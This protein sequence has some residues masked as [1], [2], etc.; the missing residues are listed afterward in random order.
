MTILPAINC[1]DVGCVA[2]R[3]ATVRLL[4]APW[5][6][7]DVA[8]GVFASP[9]TLDDPAAFAHAGVKLDAHLMI[10]H[11]EDAARRWRQ[12]ASRITVHLESA[13]LIE[14][15]R[16]R[17]ACARENIEFGVSLKLETDIA[18]AEP[19]IRALTPSLVHVLAV[20]P[21]PSGQK[22]DE[23]ALEKV[24]IL[25][26][27][28]PELPIEIDGGVTPEVVRRTEPFGATHAAVASYIFD[29]PDPR[30]RYL[31]LS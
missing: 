26:A 11:P 8:D 1:T 2:A 12:V 7:I 28:F 29:S 19:F 4:G 17:K 6:H 21:G 22:F 24:R 10:A 30:A 5:A 18:F 14:L 25:R 20:P 3:L 16:I 27:R 9:K 15:E 23:A 13:P 31:E